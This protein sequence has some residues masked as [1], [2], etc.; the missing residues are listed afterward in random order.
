MDLRKRE[1]DEIDEI[2]DDLMNILLVVRE[3]KVMAVL[4]KRSPRMRLATTRVEAAVK[5][6]L[7]ELGDDQGM[8]KRK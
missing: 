2:A 3:R 4:R 5:S 8:E 1:R 6:L 7:K